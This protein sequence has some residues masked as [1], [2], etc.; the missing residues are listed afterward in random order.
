MD[1]TMQQFFMEQMQLIQNL[2]ATVQNL[3]AQQNQ[4]PPQGPLPPPPPV[5]KHREFMSHNP[6]TYSHSV[7]PL[8]ADDWLKTINKMLNITQCNDREKVLYAS[9]RLEGAASIGGMLTSSHMLLPTPLPG[10]SFRRV[11]VHITS[12]LV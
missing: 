9:G 11:F 3:H 4:P 10:R 7:D 8:D 1:P 12:Q 6:P 2:T 5:N